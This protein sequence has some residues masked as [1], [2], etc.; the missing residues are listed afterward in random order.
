MIRRA[1][2]DLVN[3]AESPGERGR[4]VPSIHAPPRM[5]HLG[6]VKCAVLVDHDVLS[7]NVPFAPGPADIVAERPRDVSIAKVRKALL[8]LGLGVM[9]TRV[10]CELLNQGM[11]TASE[12]AERTAISRGHIYGVLEDL[13]QGAMIAR[14][15]EKVQQFSAYQPSVV[16]PGLADRRERELAETRAELSRAL[17]AIDLLTTVASEYLIRDRLRILYTDEDIAEFQMRLFRKART[18]FL[19]FE[20]QTLFPKLDPAEVAQNPWYHEKTRAMRRCR[21][22]RILVDRRV[23]A[24]PTLRQRVEAASHVQGLNLRLADD[25]PFHALVIDGRHVLMN[26]P[27]SPKLPTN[28]QVYFHHPGLAAT[29]AEEFE[30]RWHKAPR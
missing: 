1:V 13:H 11:L 28:P 22:G 2:L 29:L 16:L 8:E 17:P 12:L 5:E 26:L 3:G 20:K 21:D 23:L 27:E 10:Y 19:L 15:D 24:S 4:E 9:H 18:S 30:R 6:G 7:R 25:L 14:H